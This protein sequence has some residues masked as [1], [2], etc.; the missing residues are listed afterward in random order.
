MILA[1][2][3]SVCRTYKFIDQH[4]TIDWVGPGYI[5]LVL[6]GT[7]EINFSF[8][9]IINKDKGLNLL[10]WSIPRIN[11]INKSSCALSIE[12]VDHNL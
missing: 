12:P 10:G 3:W 2:L 6:V 4:T 8:Q 9:V 11:S 1:L 7:V 5:N